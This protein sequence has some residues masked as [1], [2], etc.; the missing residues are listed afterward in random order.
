MN[1]KIKTIKTKLIIINNNNKNALHRES[2]QFILVLILF[3]SILDYFGLFKFDVV[4][5]K[6]VIRLYI[7]K[8]W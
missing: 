7:L 8:I 4:F 1:R 3:Q 6:T 2:I 5:M